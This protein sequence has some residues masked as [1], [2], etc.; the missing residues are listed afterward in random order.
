MRSHAPFVILTRHIFH[1]PDLNNSC[2]IDQYIDLL[3]LAKN[4]GDCLFHLILVPNIA[5]QRS[6]ARTELLQLTR[7]A[8]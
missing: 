1:R 5:N 7:A 3:M 8:L 6:H 4:E 2:I